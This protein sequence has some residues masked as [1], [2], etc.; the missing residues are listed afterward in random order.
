MALLSEFLE[1]LEIVFQ[2]DLAITIGERRRSPDAA[3]RNSSF[4]SQFHV[5]VHWGSRGIEGGRS[6]RDLV[7]SIVK[8]RARDVRS[9]LHCIVQTLKWCH[10][11][12]EWVISCPN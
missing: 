7:T 10:S 3:G 8:W 11:H 2:P 4:G 6:L 9:D 5:T 1:E 12:S